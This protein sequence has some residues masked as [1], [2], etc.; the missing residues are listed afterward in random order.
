VNE[1]IRNLK[2]KTISFFDEDAYRSKNQDLRE[3]KKDEL[4]EHFKLYGYKERRPFGFCK[5]TVDRL[6]MKYLRGEGL[7]IGAGQV[8][9]SLYGDTKCIYADISEKT[10]FG[11][12][13]NDRIIFDINHPEVLS[14]KF[15]F[16]IASHVLEHVDSLLNGLKTIAELLNKDGIAYIILPNIESDSDQY[17]MPK[18]GYLHHIIEMFWPSAFKRRHIKDFCRGTLANLNPNNG[19][20]PFIENFTEELKE[21]MANNKLSKNYDYIFHRHNYNFSDWFTLLHILSKTCNRSLTLIDS[22]IGEERTD[23]HFVFKLN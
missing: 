15:D 5:T 9:I 10:V 22:S 20:N 1:N 19:W 2:N 6:S 12:T 23:C 18:F 8:P 14:Q 7:E 21:D 17:W 3:L 13:D 11:S 4:L 16:V